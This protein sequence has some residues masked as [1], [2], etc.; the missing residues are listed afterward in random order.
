ME[1][2]LGRKGPVA[3][4]PELDALFMPAVNT[5]SRWRDVVAVTHWHLYNKGQIDGA[6]F[7]VKE[8]ELGHI[9]LDGEVH[10][11]TNQQLSDPLVAGNLAFPFPYTGYRHWVMFRITNKQQAKHASWLFRLN[12]NRLQGVD[13]SILLDRIK[14]RAA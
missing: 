14:Q 5:I 4:P 1:L 7:Y 11:A 12:Y 6:D 8:R 2:A 9:H 3:P 13:D 10:L